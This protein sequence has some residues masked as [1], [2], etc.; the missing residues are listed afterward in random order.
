MLAARELPLEMLSTKLGA[1]QLKTKGRQ[2]NNIVI[3]GGT[4]S[5]QKDNL[6]CRQWR[7][8]CQFD[9]LLFSVNSTV[10]VAVVVEALV[11]VLF[12]FPTETTIHAV[13]SVS[14]RDSTNKFE[15]SDCI[16]LI[17]RQIAWFLTFCGWTLEKLSC[18][19]RYWCNSYF[20]HC[21][22]KW[23]REWLQYYF[24][25]VPHYNDVIMGAMASQIT[26]FAIV[27]SIVNS[28]AVQR[29][30]QSFVSLAFVGGIHREPVNSRTN[31][32]L[33]GKCFHLMSSSC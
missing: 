14:N 25:T 8:C 17:S 15:N 2:I 23:I 30:H 24:I 20:V 1:V 5:C 3:T 22:Y 26:S 6:R 32:Q 18:L 19:P 12:S 31:G 4:V 33:R 7:Q 29:K 27:Y 13:V 9:D 10:T 21:V 11:V 16:Q 28:D